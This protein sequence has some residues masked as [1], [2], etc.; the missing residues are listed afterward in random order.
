[1]TEKQIERIKQKIRKQKAA[2]SSE[3]RVYGG[4]HDGGGRR[5]YISDLYMQISD[6]KG[7]ITY[8]K[9]FD[10]NFPDDI[11]SPLLSLYWSIAFFEINK[12]KEAKIYTIDTAFQNIYL[13]RL[14]LGQEV[15]R[16]D[17]HEHG[18]D[19]LDFAKQLQKESDEVV[20]KS[21][22]DWLEEFVETEEYKKWIER[23]ISLNKLLKDEQEVEKRVVLLD[24]ISNLISENKN[25]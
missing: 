14:L 11:G 12:I 7:V 15:K 18:Y 19:V 23:F 2:L 21:Y 3:K 1:M 4:I 25:R 5:Y 13:H 20:T 17:M 16:I 9:W 8:K 10:R 24:H 6:Y 22:L